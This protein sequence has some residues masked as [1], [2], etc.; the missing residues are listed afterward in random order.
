MQRI[1]RAFKAF[2]SALRGDEVKTDKALPIAKSEKSDPSHLRLLAYLQGSGRLIDF[3]KEDISAYSDAEVGAAVREVH[4]ECAKALEE[5]VTVRPIFDEEEGS[6]VK[7]PFGYDS[8]SIKLTGKVKE[9]PY[10][11]TLV[12]RGWKAH[13]RSLPK[14]LHDDLNEIVQPAEIELK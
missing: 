11:G 12:H 9:P 10:E 7:V 13:K 1:I 8:F 6:V 3:L 2:F 5:L 14:N 4:K